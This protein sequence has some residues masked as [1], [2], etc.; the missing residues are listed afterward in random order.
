MGGRGRMPGLAYEAPTTR[1]KA[2]G[3]RMKKDVRRRRA[4]PLAHHPHLT[5]AAPPASAHHRSEPQAPHTAFGSEERRALS[6]R[7]PRCTCTSKAC[8]AVSRLALRPPSGE[9]AGARR[10]MAEVHIVSGRMIS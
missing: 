4:W 1:H 8:L 3:T 6:A 9:R 2:T 7:R 5:P 10:S